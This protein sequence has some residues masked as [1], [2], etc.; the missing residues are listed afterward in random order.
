ME[1]MFLDWLEAIFDY[2]DACICWVV[3][4]LTFSLDSDE[5]SEVTSMAEKINKDVITPVALSIITICFLISFLKIINKEDIVRIETYAKI[6]FLMCFSKSAVNYSFNLCRMLYNEGVKLIEH[7]SMT[8]YSDDT[9]DTFKKNEKAIKS[10]LDDVSVLGWVVILV[11]SAIFLI[12]IVVVP[13]MVAVISWGR[14]VEILILM[15]GAS[16][17]MAFLPLEH[18]GKHMIKTYFKYFAS[19]VLQG[20][21]IVLAMIICSK[22]TGTIFSSMDDIGLNPEGMLGFLVILLNI[23]INAIVMLVTIMKSTQIAQKWLGQ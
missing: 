3:N 7:A 2:Y 16:L 14:Y 1:D 18:E 10:A 22:L 17:P 20:F 23:F 6:F 5:L 4:M 9:F 13:A 12:A 8:Y 11:F 19:V 21:V 15:C